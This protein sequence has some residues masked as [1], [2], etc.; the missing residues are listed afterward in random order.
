MPVK[1]TPLAL[2]LPLAIT[3]EI[4]RFALPAKLLVVAVA[5][6]VAM[7]KPRKSIVF[8]APSKVK[9]LLVVAEVFSRV[10]IFKVVPVPKRVSV[11]LV[12]TVTVPA[13]K[14]RSL[15]AVPA[16]VPKFRP[17]AKVT[18][19]LAAFTTATPLVLLIV[20]A[21][22]VRVPD[23][24]AFALF[25]FKAPAVSVTPPDAAELLPLKVKVPAVTVVSPL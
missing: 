21:V 24:R 18:A 9:V 20:P 1:V 14:S 12:L 16:D 7:L 8:P 2:R 3:P 10:P 15:D 11:L 17:D 23:P 13:P 4:V 19:L 5:V 22:R 6:V 25:T